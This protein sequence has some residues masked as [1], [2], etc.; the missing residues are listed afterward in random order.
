[1]DVNFTGTDMLTIGGVGFATSI[2]VQL[3]WRK[4]LALTFDGAGSAGELEDRVR[5]AA[6]GLSLNLLAF[7]TALGLA[8]AAQALFVAVDY[9]SFFEGFLVAVG[10][11]AWAVGVGEVGANASRV[12]KIT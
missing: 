8:L 1:M 3:F 10:G 6:Y 5:A 11:T 4:V 12:L 7:V 9:A 2:I